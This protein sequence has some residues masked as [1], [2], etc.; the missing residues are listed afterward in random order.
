[1]KERWY[2]FIIM[3]L[4]VLMLP[5]EGISAAKK[6]MTMAELALY[7]GADRQQVLE[8]GA[9]KEK[10]LTLYTMG[11]LTQGVQLTVSAFEKRYPFIKVNIWRASGAELI[12][13]VVE[14]FRSGQSV[15]D[16]IEGQDVSDAVFVANGMLQPYYTPA[17]AFTE[18]TAIVPAPGG[19][20]FATGFRGSNVSLGYNNKLLSKDQ[21]PKTYQDLLDPKWKGKI[22]IAGGSAAK[23]LGV[24]LDTL[25]EDFAK[26]LAQQNFPVHPVS[27]M[28][29]LN[30]ISSGEY[31]LSTT[32]YDSH[33]SESKKKGAPVD[34]FPIEP[35]YSN[36][37]TIA[38]SKLTSHPH[39]A[40]LLI[41]FYL[42]Q[43]SVTI[44]KNAGYSSTRLDEPTHTNYKR[45]YGPK[46]LE[47][48]KR[49]NDTF[50][51]LFLKK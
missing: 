27:G 48:A 41:D 28:A 8:E 2:F 45:F 29:V 16:V 24:I 17:L 3:F 4:F 6:P 43:D 12:S 18:N 21:I 37:G 26:R 19:S 5:E 42:S 7:K 32:I 14:E 15:A 35:V 47:D 39:A 23:W 40:L 38:M 10:I 44:H 46:T 36:L 49:W 13:R 33:V 9:K 34:W 31:A 50:N 20:S 11:I 51:R 1:M 30:L 25:G 22:V